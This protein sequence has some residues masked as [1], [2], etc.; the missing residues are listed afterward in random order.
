MPY[1]IQGQA[2][3][4]PTEPEV[5]D[6][7]TY[8]PLREVV[9]A[10]GGSLSWDNSA[11]VATATIANWVARVDPDNT[12]VDVSNKGVTLQAPPRLDSDGTVWVPASFFNTAFGYQVDIN[13]NNISI[14]NPNAPMPA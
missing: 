10:L 4:I 14:V 9:E 2:A 6:G 7:R 5:R 8:V 1:T 11:K 12:H 3:Q 13:G